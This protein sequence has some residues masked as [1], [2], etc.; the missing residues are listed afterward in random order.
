VHP[1]R[2][3]PRRQFL[4]EEA[5]ACSSPIGFPARRGRG[6]CAPTPPPTLGRYMLRTASLFSC[7][8]SL[9]QRRALPDPSP[10]R[11]TPATASATEQA[12]V[13][14]VRAET[15]PRRIGATP[16]ASRFGVETTDMVRSAAT[17]LV[18]PSDQCPAS[19]HQAAGAEGPEGYPTLPPIHQG[20]QA[21]NECSPTR[22]GS[23]H[24]HA[25]LAFLNSSPAPP[26]VTFN[27]AASPE[28]LLN[29]LRRPHIHSADPRWV[30]ARSSTPNQT[31]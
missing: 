1:W 27:A 7:R 21:R 9:C 31:P 5:S 23:H 2:D 16:S 28:H 20:P 25:G 3:R 19:G 11:V 30:G 17:F 14:P 18:Q 24:L 13:S 22:S 8:R 29:F 10:G 6:S 26:Y 4:P 12:G 15:P